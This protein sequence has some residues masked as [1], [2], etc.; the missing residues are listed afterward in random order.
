MRAYDHVA[1]TD[2]GSFDWSCAQEIRD[3]VENSIIVA[4]LKGIHA[5]KSGGCL[6]VADRIAK[7]YRMEDCSVER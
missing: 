3:I 1:S 6:T 5:Y 4:L 7:E 2:F